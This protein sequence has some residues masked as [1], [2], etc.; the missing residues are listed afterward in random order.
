MVHQAGAI[1]WQPQ[2]SRR[3]QIGTRDSEVGESAGGSASAS[4]F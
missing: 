2:H 3:T 1:L 4:L